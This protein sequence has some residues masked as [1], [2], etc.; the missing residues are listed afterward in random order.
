MPSKT[1][2]ALITASKLSPK[3]GETDE[4][5]MTRVHYE[6]AGGI[7]EEA[8]NGLPSEAQDWNNAAAVTIDNK[9]PLPPFADMTEEAAAPASSR[10]RGGAAA[11]APAVYEPKLGDSVTVTTK[12]GGVKTGVIVELS[13]DEI[14]IN[15]K[16]ED[17]EKEDDQDFVR[18]N[19]IVTQVGGAAAAADDEPAG[20]MD[21]EIGDTVQVVTSRDKTIMGTVIELD[22]EA[23]TLVL[24]DPSGA[25]HELVPSRLKSMVVKHRPGVGSATATANTATK[26]AP[27]P[28][29]APAGRRRGAA[30]APAAAA[31]ADDEP[32]VNVGS[33]IR[34]VIVA[35]PNA[36]QEDCE[37]A[38]N[39]AKVTFSPVTV[40]VAHKQTQLA[41]KQ[42]MAKHGIK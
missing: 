9:K 31:P 7:S 1:K 16:G 37:K 32:K 35:N 36:T 19:V 39:A 41:V 28:A 13:S 26:E 21:P 17:G 8:W 38:L 23:D 33:V 12:R 24:K 10:R 34:D 29:P 22:M 25:D 30:A 42:T 3:R 14:V 18:A 20:P 27:P 6:I 15:A 2:D 4:E 40:R 11:A 5:F